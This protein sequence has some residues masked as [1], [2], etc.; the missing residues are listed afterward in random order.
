[1]S[2]V[3]GGRSAECS[4]NC[5]Y[6]LLQIHLSTKKERCTASQGKSGRFK[7]SLASGASSHPRRMSFLLIRRRI[8]SYDGR[9]YIGSSATSS[10]G[11]QKARCKCATVRDL[12]I[13]KDSVAGGACYQR[14]QNHRGTVRGYERCDQGTPVS[15]QDRQH[16]SSRHIMKQHYHHKPGVGRRLQGH[17]H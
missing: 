9:I 6:A 12:R 7:P 2:A 10:Q 1:M 5:L 4:S 11:V 15:L 8:L 13:A 14:L 16:L 17:A 3:S